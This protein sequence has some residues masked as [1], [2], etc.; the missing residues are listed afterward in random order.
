MRVHIGRMFSD[1]A[2][3]IAIDEVGRD[4]GLEINIKE[5][6]KCSRQEPS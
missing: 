1:V 3:A 2:K 5:Q 4:G 6:I